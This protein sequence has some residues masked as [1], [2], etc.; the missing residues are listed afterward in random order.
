MSNSTIGRQTL[1]EPCPDPWAQRHIFYNPKTNKSIPARCKRWSC[2]AC[3]KINYYKVDYLAT[4]GNPQRFITLTRAGQTS[5]EINYNLKKLIQGLRRLGLKFEYFGVNELHFNLQ[6]HLHLMQ[7]GDFILQAE[8]SAM[9]EKYTAK[10]YG[11]HG[12]SIVDI[13]YIH[14]NQNVKGYLLKYLKKSWEL[15]SHNPKSWAALQVAY[16]GLNHYRMSK[17]WLV[18][19]AVKADKWQIILKGMLP[20]GHSEKWANVDRFMVEDLPP[21]DPAEKKRLKV[22][23][24]RPMLRAE[25][26]RGILECTHSIA[27]QPLK[28]GSSPI[29]LSN[30]LVAIVQ[31]TRKKKRGSYEEF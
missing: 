14:P 9:W 31:P 26:S 25:V 8:L 22:I 17:G 13:R 24:P 16:P 10:S 5:Q 2:F 30:G 27:E 4:R 18:D 29:Q 11:G 19:P 6:A 23:V 1:F 3:A 28:P 20:S 21:L 12:S 7:R 15:D